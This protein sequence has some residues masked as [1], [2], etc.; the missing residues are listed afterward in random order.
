[1]RDISYAYIGTAAFRNK[2]ASYTLI[3]LS[4]PKG[5]KAISVFTVIVFL[6]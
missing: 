2:D 6:Q 1:M 3:I 4:K 5:V